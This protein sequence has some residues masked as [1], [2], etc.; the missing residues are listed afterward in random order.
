MLNE[1][2]EQVTTPYRNV[3][4]GN[5]VNVVNWGSEKVEYNKDGKRY[6][7]YIKDFL[8]EYEEVNKPQYK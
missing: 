3:E 5:I 1:N 4:V 2:K 6:Y 8:K 7:A